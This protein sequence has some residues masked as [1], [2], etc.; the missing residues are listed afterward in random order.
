[1]N[2]EKMLFDGVICVITLS[3]IHDY[4]TRVKFTFLFTAA[5]SKKIIILNFLKLDHT[6][7]FKDIKNQ[8]VNFNNGNNYKPFYSVFLIPPIKSHSWLPSCIAV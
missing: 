2:K 8:P 3:L 1:M 7:F 6:H 5:L 4:L